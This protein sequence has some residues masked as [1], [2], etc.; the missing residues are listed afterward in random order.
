MHISGAIV[1]NVF[2]L[3]NSKEGFGEDY[4][5]VTTLIVKEDQVTSFSI[6]H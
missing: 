3:H 4:V 6:P 5:N 1:D 2:V